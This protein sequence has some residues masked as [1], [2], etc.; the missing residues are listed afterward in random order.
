LSVISSTKQP[1]LAPLRFP[2][3]GIAITGTPTHDKLFRSFGL[4]KTSSWSQAVSM[5]SFLQTHLSV[6]GL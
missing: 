5:P 4:S 1:V 2:A 6:F 3:M